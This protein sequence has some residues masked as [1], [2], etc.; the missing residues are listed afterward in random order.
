MPAVSI[1]ALIALM[2][3][4]GG[5]KSYRLNRWGFGATWEV[6]GHVPHMVAFNETVTAQAMSPNSA[7]VTWGPG[8]FSDVYS[9]VL[10]QML[11][12]YRGTETNTTLTGMRIVVHIAKLARW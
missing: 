7:L 6:R 3:P 11:E 8:N 10:N 4:S 12:V 2:W 5:T 1:E 9:V